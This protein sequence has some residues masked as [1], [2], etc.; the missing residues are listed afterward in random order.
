MLDETVN[1]PKGFSLELSI[2]AGMLHFGRGGSIK[3]EAVFDRSA[4]EHL[5]E[6]P[7][8]EDQ[9]LTDVDASRVRLRATVADTM[10]LKW[11]LLAF[12]DNVEI[13]APVELRRHF[14]ATARALVRIYG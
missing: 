5:H 4:A 2:A 6:T 9:R 12:G 8:S 7:L 3:L 10:Q 11:W 14:Q 1:R 13:I